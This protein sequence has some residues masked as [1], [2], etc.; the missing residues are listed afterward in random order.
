[1]EPIDVAHGEALCGSML[2]AGLLNVMRQKGLLKSDEIAQLVD[3]TLL[4]L[5]RARGLGPGAI[6]FARERLEHL[7]Q[8]FRPEGTIP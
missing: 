8:G 5:E 6:D 3:S 1:M 2:M 4:S 7:L